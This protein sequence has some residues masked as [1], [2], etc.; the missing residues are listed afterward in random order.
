MSMKKLKIK[1][2][3]SSMFIA[4]E[5]KGICRSLLGDAIDMSCAVTANVTGSEDNEFYVCSNTQAPPLAKH[6]PAER[7][8]DMEL[9]PTIAFFVGIA[10]IPEGE[11]VC[12]FN[13]LL[14]YIN[15]LISEFTRISPGRLNFLPVAYEEME[16]ALI[17]Q[18]LREARYIVGVDC[19]VGENVLL[20]GRYRSLL[21]PE[22]KIIAG[23]RTASLKSSCSLLKG[24]ATYYLDWGKEALASGNEA[25]LH[26]AS[27]TLQEIIALIK[28]GTTKAL[29]NQIGGDG[30]TCEKERIAVEAQPDITQQIQYQLKLLSFLQEK[31]GMVTLE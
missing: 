22:V 2:V 16:E 1:A 9:K 7:L 27:D 18:R 11:T 20:S 17:C 29:L 23:H 19:F 12:V 30:T 13:N 5:I 26:D 14:P 4:E 15:L 28:S 10:G 3:G 25:D 8:F 21:S 24:I 31:V 6:V